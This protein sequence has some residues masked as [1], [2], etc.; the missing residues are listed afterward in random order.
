MVEWNPTGDVWSRADL[1]EV[2]GADCVI[3]LHDNGQTLL[4]EARHVRPVGGRQ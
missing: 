4:V 1:L 2:R 3:R